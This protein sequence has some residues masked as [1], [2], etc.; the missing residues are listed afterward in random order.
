MYAVN[1]AHLHAGGVLHPN[2]RL[3]D[4]IRHLLTSI[5]LLAQATTTQLD[6]ILGA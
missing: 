6:P 3:H 1:R 4:D 2:A 5:G